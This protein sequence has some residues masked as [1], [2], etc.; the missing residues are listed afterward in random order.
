[1]PAA[2]GRFSILLWDHEERSADGAGQTGSLLRELEL[3]QFRGHFHPFRQLE[4]DGPLLWIVHR[5]HDVDHQAVFV[6][7]V[8]HPEIF[9]L[10][11]RRFQ[12]LGRQLDAPLFLQDP[13][14]VIQC[15]R[16]FGGRHGD[17]WVLV[18]VPIVTG[19]VGAQS[20]QRFRHRRRFQAGRRHL[21]EIHG[22]SH[23]RSP[24][25]Y[26]S[27]SFLSD[28]IHLPHPYLAPLRAG[29]PEM[30]VCSR[31]R[32]TMPFP[33]SERVQV[34]TCFSPLSQV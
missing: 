20:G 17:K 8:S 2:F 24:P 13:V 15:F 1:L 10:E 23:W 26:C 5:V 21:F 34:I 28:S 7:D 12:R 30:P 14:H 27:R 6:K 9:H 16:A 33:R 3:L 18:L 4:P 11:L 32:F 31:R 19:L 22:V 25:D 29:S